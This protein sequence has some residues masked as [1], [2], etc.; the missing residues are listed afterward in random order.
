MN[1]VEA[2]RLSRRRNPRPAQCHE[3]NERRSRRDLRHKRSELRGK[4]NNSNGHNHSNG[5]YNSSHGRS[6][7]LKPNA[8]DRR[9]SNSRKA[10]ALVVPR[11]NRSKTRGRSSKRSIRVAH[12]L[13]AAEVEAAKASLANPAN[14]RTRLTRMVMGLLISRTGC[15]SQTSSGAYKPQFSTALMAS[16]PPVPAMAD[17]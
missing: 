12:L 14:R 17:G 1:A 2:G 6:H 15:A 3:S 10:N 4:C 9:S 5:Q 8:R 11:H 7:S 16:K 13:N